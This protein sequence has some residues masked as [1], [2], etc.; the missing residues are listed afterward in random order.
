MNDRLPPES[1]DAW[2][3]RARSD[4]ALARAA[5]AYAYLHGRDFVIPDDIIAIA[6]NVLRHRIL[7]SY[8]A[9]AN[10]VTADDIIDRLIKLVPV[11]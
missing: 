9:Q 1:P 4:L 7:L 3:E 8:T 2:L 11:P 6:N 5:S 10:K